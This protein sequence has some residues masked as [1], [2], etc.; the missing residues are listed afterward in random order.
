[1][2][3]KELSALLHGGELL[4]QVVTHHAK[5]DR[6]SG[7][8]GIRDRAQLIDDG[9][10]ET[11]IAPFFFATWFKKLFDRFQERFHPLGQ[12]TRVLEVLR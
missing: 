5:I 10:E 11:D 4:R 3:L 2:A 7:L 1:M 9:S 8:E 6:R 12:R